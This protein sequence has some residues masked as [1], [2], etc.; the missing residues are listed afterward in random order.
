MTATSDKQECE[1]DKTLLRVAAPFVRIGTMLARKEC[2]A[3]TLL[4]L[5][6]GSGGSY[7]GGIPYIE[8][9]D[10]WPR[11]ACGVDMKFTLQVDGRDAAHPSRL[12]GVFSVFEPS[13]RHKIDLFKVSASARCSPIVHYHAVSSRERR[14]ALAID[15]S[16][17]VALL[18]AKSTAEFL[19]VAELVETLIP[20]LGSRLVAAKLHEIWKWV[21]WR[22]T[23]E[24]GMQARLYDDHLGGWWMTNSDRLY[25][26]PSCSA[27]ARIPSLV[28]QLEAGDGNHS[29][30]AC[31]DHPNEAH[32][33]WHK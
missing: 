13:A 16:E 20:E 29:L 25:M 17:K 3:E 21:Y 9:G 12:P 27:C 10:E 18:V 1:D 11:C 28:A 22:A 19:P 7:L 8:E 33:T 5:H 15:P 30:W 32:F 31:V 26:P 6:D 2:P 14:R 24:N 4:T 23:K